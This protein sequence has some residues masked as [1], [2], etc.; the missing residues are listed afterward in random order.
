MQKP[1]LVSGIQNALSRG[2]SLEQAKRSFINAGYN[3]VDVEDSARSF[4]GVISN[5]PQRIM[6][7]IPQQ[8]QQK[9]SSYSQQQKPILAQQPSSSI[10][11]LTNSIPAIQQQRSKKPVFWVIIIIILVLLFLSLI[12]FLIM[13][14]WFREK[15]IALLPFLENFS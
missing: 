3:P 13:E 12:G 2:S 6:P 10:Q 15:L 9:P 14:V 7:S 11:Q 4:L 1:E 8:N 5:I